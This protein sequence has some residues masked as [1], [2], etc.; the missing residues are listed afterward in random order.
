MDLLLRGIAGVSNPSALCLHMCH[1]WLHFPWNQSAEV[2]IVAEG[3]TGSVPHS[4][5]ELGYSGRGSLSITYACKRDP[6]S[7]G[8]VNSRKLSLR[9]TFEAFDSLPIWVGMFDVSEF[10]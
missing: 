1:N 8:I 5:L 7:V 2:S 6:S 10:S 9:R 4:I 3:Q